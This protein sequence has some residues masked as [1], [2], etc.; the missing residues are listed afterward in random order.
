M[1]LGWI[2]LVAF[3]LMVFGVLIGW[4]LNQWQLEVRARR[5]AAA[6]LS[7]YKQL[8]D[9]QAARQNNPSASSNPENSANGYR[10]RAA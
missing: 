1:N 3:V 8:H 10:R 2:T 4:R 9:L 5:Q 7:L 6:Q